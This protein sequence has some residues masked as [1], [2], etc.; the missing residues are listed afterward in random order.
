MRDHN[1]KPKSG[2]NKYSMA[3]VDELRRGTAFNQNGPGNMPCR[4]LKKQQRAY[5]WARN[6]IKRTVEETEDPP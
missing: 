6:I 4:T 1:R 3:I 5:A 2:R